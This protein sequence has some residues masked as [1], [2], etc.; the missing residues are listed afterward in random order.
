MRRRRALLALPLL[1]GCAATGGAPAGEAVERVGEAEIRRL[2]PRLLAEI[3]VE[4]EDEETARAL[5]YGPL[6]RVAGPSAPLLQVAGERV[7]LTAPLLR[8]R[9]GWRWR[10]GMALPAQAAVERPPDGAVTLREAPAET[11]AVFRFDGTPTP[12]RVAGAQARLASLVAISSWEAAGEGGAALQWPSRLAPA[13]R[14]H[15]AWLPVRRR[16]ALPA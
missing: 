12:E 4:A 6:S 2:P 8:A 13:L 15:A 7:P 16:Q 5:G 3:E 11:V 1:A 14:R 10:F 9:D